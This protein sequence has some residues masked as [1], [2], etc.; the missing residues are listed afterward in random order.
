MDQ[1]KENQHLRGN[2][3][4][5]KWFY[6][7]HRRL[8]KP[9]YPVKLPCPNCGRYFIEVSADMI[10][11]DNYEG[12]GYL[13]ITAKDIWARIKHTCGAKITLYWKN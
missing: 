2:R 11:I 9:P 12:A 4:N 1:G 6:R 8:I 13:D 10:E 3:N 7:I 5:V